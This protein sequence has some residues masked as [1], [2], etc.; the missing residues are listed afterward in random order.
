MKLSASAKASIGDAI[1]KA[2]DAHD[3]TDYGGL[4]YSDL[5]ADW[6][7]LSWQE[8]NYLCAIAG[9]VVQQLLEMGYT[10]LSDLDVTYERCEISDY[11][12]GDR[13]RVTDR[14]AGDCYEFTVTRATGGA[15]EGASISAIDR[16]GLV[17]ERAPKPV[18]HPD[19]EVHKLI[20]DHDD[21]DTLYEAIYDLAMMEERYFSAGD[22]LGVLPRLF[23]NWSAVKLVPDKEEDSCG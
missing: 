9:G 2:W 14:S 19:P 15:V 22:N 18:V 3:L 13:A 8:R 20:V 5:A 4:G 7:G 6:L 16:P 21:H 12:E 11:K 17:F 23:T 10:S 1:A